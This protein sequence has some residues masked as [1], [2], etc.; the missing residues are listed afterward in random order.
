MEI[1]ASV[2]G[3]NEVRTMFQPLDL[4]DL[5]ARSRLCLFCFSTAGIDSISR[6][7]YNLA[8]GYRVDSKM[9][10]R[11]NYFAARQC[12]RWSALGARGGGA[13]LTAGR[14]PCIDTS[15]LFLRTK[16]FSI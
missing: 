14:S 7:V 8:I 9:K 2:D 13:L 10:D 15:S 4:S 12:G 16:S 11:R 1:D 3:S 6:K 5:A